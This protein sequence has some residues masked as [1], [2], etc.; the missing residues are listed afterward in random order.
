MKI[1]EIQPQHVTETMSG[2]IGSVA[3]PLFKK[4]IIKRVAE[5]GATPGGVAQKTP[6]QIRQDQEIKK[7]LTQLKG[8]GVDID[9][10]KSADDP[11]NAGNVA[12]AVQKAMADPS[13]ATQLKTTLQK[14][15]QK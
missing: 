15:Q 2:S 6:D 3:T 9:P 7:N 14:A 12:G 10:N 11:N 1:K 13:L 8:A 5:Y 4:K